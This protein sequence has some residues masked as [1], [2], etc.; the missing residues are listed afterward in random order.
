MEPTH[1]RKI[2]HECRYAFLVAG[3]KEACRI[4]FAEFVKCKDDPLGFLFVVCVNEVF[5]EKLPE[6]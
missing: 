1:S 6:I 3:A 4:L 5:L 2:C